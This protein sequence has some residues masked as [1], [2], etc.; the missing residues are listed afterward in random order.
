MMKNTSY[1]AL[2]L[3]ICAILTGCSTA[4]VD[5][6]CNPI[7]RTETWS[8]VA[9]M[10]ACE[11]TSVFSATFIDVERGIAYSVGRSL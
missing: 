2:A 4:G 7:N 6:R 9:P 1:A 5:Q 8:N 3:G 10:M 11:T